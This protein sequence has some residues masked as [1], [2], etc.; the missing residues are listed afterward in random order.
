LFTESE[1]LK[2]NTQPESGNVPT[3]I[4]PVRDDIRKS[5]PRLRAIDPRILNAMTV[6]ANGTK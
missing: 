2:V 4:R 1:A 5:S 3:P 6:Y